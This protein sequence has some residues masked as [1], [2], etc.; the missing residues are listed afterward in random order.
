MKF[1]S[2][3]ILAITIVGTATLATACQSPNAQSQ[4]NA[5]PSSAVSPAQAQDTGGADNSTPPH[6]GSRGST[7][8]DRLP[9]S[10]NLTDDQKSKI[11]GIQESYRSKMNSILTTEQKNQLKAARQQGKRTGMKS[12]NLTDT[13]KQQIKDMRQSQR[14]EI[15]GVLTDQQKQQ[16]QQTRRQ[17]KP[18][19]QGE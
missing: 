18:A 6:S 13:Q 15:E 10:L 12:L 17:H 9:S 14:Q 11:K 7:Y 3:A 16:L 4:E 2:L 19:P 8:G 1:K 5:A